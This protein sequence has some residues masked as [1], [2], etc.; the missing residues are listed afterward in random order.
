MSILAWGWAG[1]SGAAM[2]QG[3]FQ[4]LPVF[5]K[6]LGGVDYPPPSGELH[7]LLGVEA[8]KTTPRAGARAPRQ[9]HVLVEESWGEEGCAG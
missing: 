3:V 4:I 2:G 9:S 1:V 8:P 7:I 5:P 6:Q